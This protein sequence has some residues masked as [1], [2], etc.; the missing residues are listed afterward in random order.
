MPEREGKRRIMRDSDNPILEEYKEDL[1]TRP[2]PV[3]RDEER[4]V[5][6]EGLLNELMEKSRSLERR[7]EILEK[8]G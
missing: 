3:P 2:I 8:R 5:R 4:I 6:L 1:L 7:V